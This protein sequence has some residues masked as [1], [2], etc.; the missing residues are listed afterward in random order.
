MANAPA[1]DLETSAEFA[2][3]YAPANDLVTDQDL[4]LAQ[5]MQ[6]AAEAEELAVKVKI[7]TPEQPAAADTARPAQAADVATPVKPATL[8]VADPAAETA[9]AEP[10]A[11]S[12]AHAADLLSKAPFNPANVAASVK[13]DA[14]QQMFTMNAAKTDAVDALREEGVDVPVSAT[15]KAEPG[16]VMHVDTKAAF[17]PNAIG[18]KDRTLNA[19]ETASVL[20]QVADR[21]EM[22]AAA[23]PKDGVTIQLDP[24]DLGQI[25]LKVKGAGNDVSA[26]ITAQ[27]DGVR[28]ALEQNKAQL[29]QNLEGKGLNLNQ[30]TINTSTDA[31]QGFADAQTRQQMPTQPNNNNNRTAFGNE[32]TGVVW[33]ADQIRNYSRKATGVDLFA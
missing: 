23:K 10:N 30:V 25:I 27:H 14:V 26:E 13:N 33:G 4:K 17:A 8:P 7:N 6:E 2:P 22:L 15:D 12:D 31:K 1:N 18:S 29:S 11:K 32:A 9:K 20:K 3:L 28:Q 16:F 5:L 19:V 24:G 21:L